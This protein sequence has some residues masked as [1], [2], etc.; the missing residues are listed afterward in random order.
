LLHFGES[1]DR[2]AEW[3]RAVVEAAEIVA[4]EVGL[5]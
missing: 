3:A 5:A 4:R 2:W 1:T